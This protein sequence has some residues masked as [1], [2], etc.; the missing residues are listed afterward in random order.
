LTILF[1][2]E[3]AGSP[4]LKKLNSRFRRYTSGRVRLFH[5]ANDDRKPRSVTSVL[6]F[7]LY[8]CLTSHYSREK[9]SEDFPFPRHLPT[10]SNK[11]EEE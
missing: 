1:Y 7:R 10:R 2:N 3:A 11:N 4:H 9:Y 8:F 5:V 6:S